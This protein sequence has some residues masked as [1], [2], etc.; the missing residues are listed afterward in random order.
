MAL[1]IFFHY[2]LSKLLLFIAF[3]PLPFIPLIH[4]SLLQSPRCCSSPGVLVPFCSNLYPLIT[5][6]PELSPCYLSLFCLLV[7]FF[8]LD[9]FISFHSP[10]HRIQETAKSGYPLPNSFLTG[11]FILLCSHPKVLW[12][13]SKLQ[14][15]SHLG[16]F[17][18][19][20]TFISNAH[21]TNLCTLSTHY[22]K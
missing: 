3:F 12:S 18:E 14:D 17:V 9:L 10:Q 13:S 11:T 15:V 4:P 2:D 16:D 19:T 21:S 1:F 20:A 5:P 22:S 8:R 6:H 7:K